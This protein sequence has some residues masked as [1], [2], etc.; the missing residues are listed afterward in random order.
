MVFLIL[1]A[2]NAA[3][4]P[5]QAPPVRDVCACTPGQTCGSFSCP[6]NGGVGGCPCASPPAG[7]PAASGFVWGRPASNPDLPDGFVQVG[8]P[9]APVKTA[10]AAAVGQ[11]AA[12]SA[13]I[14]AAPLTCYIDPRTGRRVCSAPTR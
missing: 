4:L 1:A 11:P 13:A 5:P 3:P 8:I 7:T 12:T 6:A 9:L 2:I 14:F 10:P